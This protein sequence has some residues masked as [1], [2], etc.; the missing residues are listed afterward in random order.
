MNVITHNFTHV[1]Q[2]HETLIPLMELTLNTQ[3]NFDM[4]K[5]IMNCVCVCVCV[6]DSKSKS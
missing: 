2:G 3:C 6:H 5:C 4:I 1:S